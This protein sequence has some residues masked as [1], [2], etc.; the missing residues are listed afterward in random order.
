MTEV[1]MSIPKPLVVS[2]RKL[3]CILYASESFEGPLLNLPNIY[4]GILSPYL[5]LLLWPTHHSYSSASSWGTAQVCRSLSGHCQQTT[6]KLTKCH[7]DSK[8]LK[9]KIQYFIS[10][11]SICMHVF[12]SMIVLNYIVT[13]NGYNA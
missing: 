13:Y 12:K 5:T 9:K 6:R 10:I 1:D 11:S 2:N 4:T 3:H 8:F 7:N